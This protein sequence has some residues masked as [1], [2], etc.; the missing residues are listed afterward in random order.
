[1]IDPARVTRKDPGTPE[2]CNIYTLHQGFSPP[3][4]VEEVAVKCRTAGW[5]CID[6]K[7]KLADGMIATLAPMRERAA[8]LQRDPQ[9][10]KERL[11]E[12]ARR[13]RALAQETMAQVRDKMGF[14]HE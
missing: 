3:E 12:G 13:A 6:C 5:G 10:V 1:V 7:R 2:I 14:L 8:A 4:V 9:G 11:R